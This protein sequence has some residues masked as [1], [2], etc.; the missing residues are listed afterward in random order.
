MG[1]LIFLLV[2]V[3]VG[4]LVWRNRRRGSVEIGQTRDIPT[5]PLD[6]TDLGPPPW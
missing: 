6:R 5:Y 3:V 2:V 1:W 4:L